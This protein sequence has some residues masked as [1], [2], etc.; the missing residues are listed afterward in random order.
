MSKTGHRAKA[1]AAAGLSVVVV[2]GGAAVYAAGRPG[3][4][5][6]NPAFTGAMIPGAG[7]PQLGSYLFGELTGQT[8]PVSGTPGTP[9]TITVTTPDGDVVTLNVAPR[10]GVYSYQGPDKRAENL[11]GVTGLRTDDVLGVY[12]VRRRVFTPPTTEAAQ[13]STVGVTP[14]TA[15][16]VAYATL[17]VDL[18]SGSTPT[19]NSPTTTTTAAG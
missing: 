15:T 7:L 12:F 9:A 8:A 10:A 6:K 3:H 17:I 13:S 2:S 19:Y 16:F 1:L 18:G 11:G 14:S 4:G 5:G